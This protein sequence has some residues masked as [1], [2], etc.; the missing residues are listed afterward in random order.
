MC[1][2]RGFGLCCTQRPLAKGLWSTL[3]GTP[4]ASLVLLAHSQTV[5]LCMSLVSSLQG[6]VSQGMQPCPCVCPQPG[7]Q[8]SLNFY[9]SKPSL[10][11]TCP[12]LPQPCPSSGPEVLFSSS[13]EKPQP[14]Q[15]MVLATSFVLDLHLPAAVW[16]GS[17]T[18][19]VWC[20]LC[21]DTR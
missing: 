3:C 9:V 2:S 8:V 19:W 15:T 10:I 4:K 16:V 5:L 20:S 7:A 12:R 18:W 1:G 11:K 6:S 13:V 17:V 21:P 14:Y